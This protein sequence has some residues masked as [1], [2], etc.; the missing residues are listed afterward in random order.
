M[1]LC[2]TVLTL[3][4]LFS[5]SACSISTT[6]RDEARLLPETVNHTPFPG[7]VFVSRNDEGTFL[8]A[9]LKVSFSVDP[10]GNIRYD[11]NQE[12][13]YLATVSSQQCPDVPAEV[14]DFV[15]FRPQAEVYL[16][17]GEKTRERSVGVRWNKKTL[18]V[19]G[20]DECPM[21]SSNDDLVVIPF[22][23]DGDTFV[24]QIES[25]KLN[26]TIPKDFLPYLLVR[27]Q[28]GA[29]IPGPARAD[30]IVVDPDLKRLLVTYRTTVRLQ[31][32]EVEG[33]RIAKLEFRAVQPESVLRSA[34][35]R[36]GSKEILRARAT[37]EFLRACPPPVVP[38]EVCISP[39]T[40]V[41]P[42]VFRTK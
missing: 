9:V 33:G 22:P 31:P 5:L 29:L 41:S 35:A 27:Y 17:P 10:G 15:T 36:P 12:G 11:L 28:S 30:T 18:A 13:L 1:K 37:R 3:M 39:E 38:G 40:Q 6:V 4:L 25:E 23:S 20:D 7:K 42:E 26:F 24:V 16:R 19:T 8:T 32:E 14:S 21:L 2:R 34:G